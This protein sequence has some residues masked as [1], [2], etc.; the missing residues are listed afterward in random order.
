MVL[1]WLSTVALDHTSDSS[2]IH[3]E[4]FVRPR[5]DSSLLI[6]GKGTFSDAAV[7][8]SGRQDYQH[9]GPGWQ[10][11]DRLDRHHGRKVPATG[12]LQGRPRY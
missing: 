3:T 1:T 7:S 2:S 11:I 4:L 6:E 12:A 5:S 10:L 9:K 8:Q